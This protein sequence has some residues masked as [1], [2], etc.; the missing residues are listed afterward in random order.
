[1]LT[2]G[3]PV[4]IKA[5]YTSFIRYVEK[6]ACETSFREV[7]KR[8]FKKSDV[9]AIQRFTPTSFDWRVGVLGNEVLYVCKYMIP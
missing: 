8:F 2:F 3:K 5:P 7:A 4:V 6:A 1:M 9:L